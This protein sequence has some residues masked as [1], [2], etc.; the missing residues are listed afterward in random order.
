MA[1]STP[2]PPGAD[3]PPPLGDVDIATVAALFGERTRARVLTAL[4]G[5]R[6]LPASVLAA[7]TGVSAPTM[8]AHLARLLDGSLVTVERNGR[9]R[10][11]RLATPAVG[12]AVEALARL[13]P[14]QPVRSLR[15]GTRARA[16][17]RARTCYDH[18]AGE[19]G[20]GLTTVLLDRGALCRED[21]ATTTDRREDDR[22]STRM[23]THPYRLGP[24]A[25]QV[26]AE[27]GVDLAAETASASRRPLL[28]FC[29]DWSEQRH[30]LAGRLGAAV[31]TALLDGGWAVRVPGTRA[32][33]LT[34]DGERGLTAFGLAG[35]RAARTTAT[36]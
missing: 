28:R 26:L 7:E 4:A 2:P 35:P 15:Q 20:V 32:L 31:A 27:L 9:H 19:L 14:Q 21:G 8:S 1:P 16:L 29:V 30:H 33:R 36:G 12:E 13:A 34:G 17:R 5:G 22:L 10:Y 24:H 25:P 6:A 3:A 18:L 11:Y 23:A